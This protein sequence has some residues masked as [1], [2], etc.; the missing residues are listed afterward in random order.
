MYT[1]YTR[2]EIQTLNMLMK[3]ALYGVIQICMYQEYRTFKVLRKVNHEKD[4]RIQDYDE[5]V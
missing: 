1:V 3:A 2:F 4:K 5:Q